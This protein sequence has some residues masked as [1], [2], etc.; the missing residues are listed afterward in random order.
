MH[1][2][3]AIWTKKYVSKKIWSAKGQWA[4]DAGQKMQHFLNISTV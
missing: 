4:S 2:I 3:V 1:G